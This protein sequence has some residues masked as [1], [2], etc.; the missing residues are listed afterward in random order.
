MG[1]SVN[2]VGFNTAYAKNN[3]AG[4]TSAPAFRGNEA[5][6]ADELVVKKGLSTG[7][8]VG[9]AVVLAALATIGGAFYRG[10]V[11]SKAEELGSSLLTKLT[12]GFKSIFV[13]ADKEK[14]INANSKLKAQKAQAAAIKGAIESAKIGTLEVDK[15]VT[16]AVE[17]VEAKIAKAHEGV[18][19]F[20]IADR[21]TWIKMTPELEEEHKLATQ[22]LADAQQ[23]AIKAKADE[24]YTET[25]EKGIAK[26][27]EAQDIKHND[28]NP[29]DFEDPKLDELLG[30]GNQGAE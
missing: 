26:I 14:F 17:A 27:K 1:M 23:S 29:E 15:S 18:E 25:Y 13:K 8:K 4:Y 24:A 28:G 3:A 2:S 21:A 30:E 11:I 20:N 5:E 16:E 9:I 12:D 22:V 6:E 7:K 10:N 19:G